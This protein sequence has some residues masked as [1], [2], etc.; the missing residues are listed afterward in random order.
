M[1]PK[2]TACPVCGKPDLETLSPPYQGKCITSDHAVLPNA[3]VDNRCCRA[4]GLIFNAGGTRG[5]T[6]D[7]YRNSY[8]L[9][10]RKETAAIQSFSGDRPISQ[11]EKSLHVLQDFTPLASRGNVLEV[12]AGK[13]EFLGY[14]AA[15]LPNWSIT[16]FE[17]SDSFRIL[18]SRLPT[19]QALRGGYTDFPEG[20]QGYDLVVALGVLEHVENPFD[21]LKWGWRQLGDNGIFFIRVPNFAVNPND[22]F[23]ADHLSKLTRQSLESMAAAAGFEILGFKEEGVPI[24]CAL[25]KL[26]AKGGK[27]PINVYG[28]N[29][30]IA[31]ANVE[32]AEASVNAVRAARDSARLKGERFA[33]FGLGSSG[34]FAP[35]Y[36]EFPPSEIAA[37]VDEN[38]TMWGSHVHDRPVGGLDTIRELGIKHI[39]LAISPVYVEKVRQKLAPFA[40]KV[41]AA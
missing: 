17:P 21:M 34:L 5:F 16:A 6:Q 10:M 3:T 11:A 28:S 30:K 14:F 13:G 7:F 29:I 20:R 41:Y 31:Q 33:V 35:F 27:L 25:R 8:S 38:K 9:M 37:Y 12:G 24:F 40:I 32:I 22:L 19:A 15:A 36:F 4:C 39:A 1:I 2:E 26:A 18:Q 23:C